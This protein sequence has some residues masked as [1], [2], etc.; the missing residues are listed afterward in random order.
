LGYIDFTVSQARFPR[1][2]LFWRPCC[3]ITII[4]S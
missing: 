3:I 1:A 2:W 4:W